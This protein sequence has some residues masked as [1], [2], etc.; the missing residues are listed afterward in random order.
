MAEE[1]NCS[2][3]QPLSGFGL[4]LAISVFDSL[5]SFKHLQEWR[6]RIRANTDSHSKAL[7]VLSPSITFFYVNCFL[8]VSWA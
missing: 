5:F 1:I 3:Q 4:Q 8:T 7:L 2:L 6:S